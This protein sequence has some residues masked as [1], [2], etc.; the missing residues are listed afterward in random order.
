M[1]AA[2][3]I[4]FVRF[5]FYEGN[6]ISAVRKKAL[7]ALAYATARDQQLAPRAILIRADL[8]ETTTIEGKR[9]K[10]PKGWHGTFAFKTD[11]QV[12]REFH[13]ASH[14]YTN[15]KENFVLT[16]ATHDPEKSDK[17]PRGGKNSGKIVWPSEDAL[18]EYVDSPIGYSH[19]PTQA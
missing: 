7:V 19:L 13:V 12:Q 6:T 4:N 10:D 3:G 5:F 15:G 2:Q 11:D 9:V 18:D 16:D 17:V 1:A 8:H 14:G